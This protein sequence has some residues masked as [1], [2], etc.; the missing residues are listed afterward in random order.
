MR[1]MGGRLQWSLMATTSQKEKGDIYI[2]YVGICTI[3]V[4]W[5]SDEVE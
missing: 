5:S 3:G 4:L 2:Y 1:G